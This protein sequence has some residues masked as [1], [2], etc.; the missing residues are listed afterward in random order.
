MICNH[1]FYLGYNIKV[2]LSV[3][4]QKQILRS[5]SDIGVPNKVPVKS[6]TF[7]F[8]RKNY[9]KVTIAFNIY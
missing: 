5:F 6:G 8:K 7:L 3:G 1:L 2:P 9:C 4:V